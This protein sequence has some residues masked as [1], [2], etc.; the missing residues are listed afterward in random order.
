ML[1]IHFSGVAPHELVFASQVPIPN[2]ELLRTHSRQL[3]QT[4]RA[5]HGCRPV[6][7]LMALTDEQIQQ[8]L[9]CHPPQ[10]FQANDDGLESASGS[11]S[12][13]R[14]ARET[15]TT[16]A[17]RLP[18][19]MA[20]AVATAVPGI[21]FGVGG[22]VVGAVHNKVE[23]QRHQAGIRR[24]GGTITIT[25][26]GCAG[27]PNLRQMATGL[28]SKQMKNTKQ[29][30]YVKAYLL[31]EGVDYNNEKGYSSK[32]EA[33]LGG[34]TDFE[35]RENTTLTLGFDPTD[36]TETAGGNAAVLIEVKDKAD[37]TIGK[38]LRSDD[39]RIGVAA[40]P[41]YQLVDQIANLKDSSSSSHYINL[42]LYHGEAILDGEAS[43]NGGVLRL[44]VQLA[45]NEK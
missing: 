11:V 26:I 21:V 2:W 32:T 39:R 37:W 14:Q 8:F 24:S 33:H 10:P 3:A 40:F 42:K 41:L 38:V 13:S 4:H 29:S 45:R 12:K 16:V 1:P 22:A 23:Q 28:G 20:L 31:M 5:R 35:F 34:G 6:L 25:C 19:N 30:P 18:V 27:L 15:V 43:P 7:S 9:S 36:G 17:G 44:H